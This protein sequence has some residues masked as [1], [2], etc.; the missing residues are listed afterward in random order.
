MSEEYLVVGEY[1]ACD[2]VWLDEIIGEFD[3]LKEAEKCRFEV[4]MD[5]CGEYRR[6]DVVKS[7]EYYGD[8]EDE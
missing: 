2:D 4:G 1:Y 3:T 5:N 6:L 7:S 8:D